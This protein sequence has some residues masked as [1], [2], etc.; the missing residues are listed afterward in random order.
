MLLES[1]KI[2]DTNPI[3]KLKLKDCL[4]VNSFYFALF[5]KSKKLKTLLISTLKIG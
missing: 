5:K 4:G 2:F 1:K 3:K